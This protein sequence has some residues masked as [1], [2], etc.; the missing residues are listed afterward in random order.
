MGLRKQFG[1]KKMGKIRYVVMGAT[2]EMAG[3]EIGKIEAPPPPDAAWDSEEWQNYEVDLLDAMIE[4][5]I[6][7]RPSDDKD[8]VS[9]TAHHNGD[10]ISWEE[11]GEETYQLFM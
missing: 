8:D 4:A 1:K 3:E 10:Y 7:A 2:E 11:D 6:D 5:G 9:G